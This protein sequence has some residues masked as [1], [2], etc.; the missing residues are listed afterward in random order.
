M[1]FFKMSQLAPDDIVRHALHRLGDIGKEPGFL[2]VIKQIEKRT[3]L[4]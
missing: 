1:H 3:W 4:A 2:T